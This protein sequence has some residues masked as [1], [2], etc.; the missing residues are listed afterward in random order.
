M[1]AEKTPPVSTGL[2][3]IASEDTEE[4]LPDMVGRLT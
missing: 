3:A 1:C 2:Q 4:E